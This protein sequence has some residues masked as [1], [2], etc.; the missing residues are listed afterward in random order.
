MNFF[1]YFVCRIFLTDGLKSYKSYARAKNG[2]IAIVPA[3]TFGF[4]RIP[5]RP[6]MSTS[7]HDVF[8][9]WLILSTSSKLSKFIW[10]PAK[11]FIGW[12]HFGAF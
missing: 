2:V 1:T 11:Y 12:D 7:A 5:I 10:T 3:P 9:N 8:N 4:T 6:E